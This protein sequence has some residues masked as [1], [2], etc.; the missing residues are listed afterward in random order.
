MRWHLWTDAVPRPGYTNMAIDLALLDR[1]EQLGEIWLRLYRWNPHCLSFGRHEPAMRRY[2]VDRIKRIGVDTVRRPT[3]GRAVWHATELTYAITAPIARFASARAAYLEI[4]HLMREALCSFGVH[5][6]LAPSTRTASLEAGSCFSQPAGGE[7][8]VNG[9][10]IVGSAQLRRG[11]SFLQHGSILLEDAQVFVDTL[12]RGGS[13][14]P[15]P[16]RLERSTLPLGRQVDPQEMAE[17]VTHTATTM[18]GNDSIPID[19]ENQILDAASGY[20]PRFQSA[21]WTWTR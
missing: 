5:G 16:S 20:F 1:T 13:P 17:A 7:V 15:A 6:S 3:G 12:K 19:N 10:K 4:H 9:R 18:W 11:S 21:D 2:D 14:A 8:L